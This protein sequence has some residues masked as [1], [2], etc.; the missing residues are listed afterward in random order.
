MEKSNATTFWKY[1]KDNRIVIPIIQRDYAQ[2]RIGKEYLRAKFLKS[3]IGTLTGGQPLILDFVYGSKSHGAVEPLDGQQRLTTLW[4]LH[5]YAALKCGRLEENKDTFRHFSYET[6]VSSRSFIDAIC[7][8]GSP[9]C[10]GGVAEYIRQR[11]W[12]LDAWHHDPT[13]KAILVM[14]EGTKISDKDGHDIVDGLEE[15]FSGYTAE[16]FAEIWEKLTD[17]GACPIRFYALNMSDGNLPLSDDLYIKMNARGRVLSDFENFKADLIDY[18]KSA[19]V[20]GLGNDYALRLGTLIDNDWMDVF[21]RTSGHPE[22]V[23]DKAFMA[24]LNRFFLTKIILS[25]HDKKLTELSFSKLYGKNGD[26][27]AF[28]YDNFEPY[29]KS[30][31]LLGDTFTQLEAIFERVS[32][33]ADINPLCKPRWTTKASNDALFVPIYADEKGITSMGQRQRVVFAAAC[34]YLERHD[35]DGQK[36]ADWMRFAWNIAENSG[37]YDVES[38]KRVIRSIGRYAENSDDILRHLSSL[39]PGEVKNAQ[40][41]EETVKARRI[42]Q[43]RDGDAPETEQHIYEAESYGFFRGAIRFL[44]TNSGGNVDWSSF[45]EK[46]ANAQ[47]LLQKAVDTDNA[48]LMCYLISMFTQWEQI[49]LFDGNTARFSN[50]GDNWKALLTSDKLQEPVDRLLRSKDIPAELHPAMAE[51]GS[52]CTDVQIK[53]QQDLCDINLMN[54]VLANVK[55]AARL[56][57]NWWH[58]TIYKPYERNERL[59]YFT[60]DRRNDMLSELSDRREFILNE[61]RALPGGRHFAGVNI[62][63]TFN[64]RAFLWSWD[65]YIYIDSSDRQAKMTSRYKVNY[66]E[67]DCNGLCRKFERMIE[68]VPE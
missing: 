60:A 22:G 46:F 51:T 52:G 39:D 4:L 25:D 63:F 19:T 54:D 14:L 27:T 7:G 37:I 12:F 24:F 49:W 43:S 47:N 11:T 20:D 33:I 9:D 17:E 21:W 28:R 42:C 64:G 68:T 44:F 34:M 5:W 8:I 57:W 61:D 35:Y 18:V 59:I 23:V 53:V 32:K 65:D 1:L 36:F 45:D 40:L 10:K 2:G 67:I 13:V 38:M 26:D 41:K 15:I 30:G 29:E 3:L 56:R 62:P 16:Q 58:H 48:S 31:V 55:G 6:R 66:D 50:G